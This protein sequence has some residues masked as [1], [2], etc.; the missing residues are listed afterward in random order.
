[1]QNL[2]FF[3]LSLISFNAFAQVEELTCQSMT[4]KEIRVIALED[5][6]LTMVKVNGVSLPVQTYDSFRGNMILVKE[7]YQGATQQ[8]KT[9][10]EKKS[11]NRYV[12]NH[13]KFCDSYFEEERCAQDELILL[14]S[15]E[16]NCRELF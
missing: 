1:M 11:K 5:H 2:C 3:I 4:F 13:Y 14:D 12:L 6:N 8:F 7:D 10:L 9:Y 15:E 16:A